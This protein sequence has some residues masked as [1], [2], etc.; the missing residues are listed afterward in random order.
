MFS[1]TM[2]AILLMRLFIEGIGTIANDE[3]DSVESDCGYSS[4]RCVETAI[5]SVLIAEQ[6]SLANG[7][8][9]T[10]KPRV[11]VTDKCYG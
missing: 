2:L 6:L 8:M 7:S 1:K 5:C 11:M 4:R 9:Q 3:D 10:F